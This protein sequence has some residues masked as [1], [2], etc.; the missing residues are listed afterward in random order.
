MIFIDYIEYIYRFKV[1]INNITTYPVALCDGVIFILC[2]MHVLYFVQ[3]NFSV[4]YCN[5]YLIRLKRGM[6]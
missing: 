4:I 2:S 5:I 6:I 1:H 3:L